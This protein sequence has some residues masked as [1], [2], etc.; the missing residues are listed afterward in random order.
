MKAS[1]YGTIKQGKDYEINYC[2]T[3]YSLIL[4]IHEQFGI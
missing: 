2:L 1:L 4:I 3:A